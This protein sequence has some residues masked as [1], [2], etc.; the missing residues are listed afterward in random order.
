[1]FEGTYQGERVAIKTLKNYTEAAREEFLGE[2]SVMTKLKHKNLVTLKGV[3][4]KGGEVM[5]VTEYMSKVGSCHCC[6]ALSHYHC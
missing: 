5:L 1:M 2:A 6:H 4:L 3:V